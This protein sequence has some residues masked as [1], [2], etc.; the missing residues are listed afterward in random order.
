MLSTTSTGFTPSSGIA[1]LWRSKPTYNLKLV[2]SPTN[3]TRSSY[4]YLTKGILH[5][6]I[7]VELFWSNRTWLGGCRYGCCCT[8]SLPWARMLCCDG[9]HLLKLL[10]TLLLWVPVTR[11]GTLLL[12]DPV[13]LGSMLL[14]TVLFPHLLLPV[15]SCRHRLLW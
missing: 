2:S 5:K 14:H 4:Y 9:R 1:F 11:A 10:W 15:A 8:G 6:I 3:P 13:V 12:L 7:N